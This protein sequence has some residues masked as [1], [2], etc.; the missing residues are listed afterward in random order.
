MKKE[1]LI[2]NVLNRMGR[3]LSDAF[4]DNGYYVYGTDQEEDFE[5]SCDRF[6]RFNLNDFVIDVNYRIKFTQIFN[7]IIPRLNI[8]VFSGENIDEESIS[9]ISLEK[10]NWLLNENIAGPLLLT[11]L[12]LERLEIGKG[13]IFNILSGTSSSES[14]V[15]DFQKMCSAALTKAVSA[16]TAD[17]IRV[18]SLSC[19]YND[20]VYGDSTSIANSLNVERLDEQKKDPL[21]EVVKTTLYLLSDKG[22]FINGADFTV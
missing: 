15:F 8:L 3:M 12:F 11:K 1:V 2:I 14:S 17:R 7:D 21:G 13:I 9:D 16:D 4:R 5:N 10:L 20:S 6:L 19:R 18:N 22:S